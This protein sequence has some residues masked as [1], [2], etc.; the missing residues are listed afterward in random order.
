MKCSVGVAVCAIAVLIGSVLALFG[1]A[2]AALAFFG[3][4]S[5]QLFDPSALPPGADVRLMRAGMLSGRTRGAGSARPP[6]N[7]AKVDCRVITYRKI[8][9]IAAQNR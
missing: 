8:P 3:P 6:L 5:G 7:C 1:A 2:G 4:L 9:A